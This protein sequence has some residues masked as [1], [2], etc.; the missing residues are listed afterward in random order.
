MKQE[1]I[2]QTKTYDFAVRTI[3]LYKHLSVTKKEYVL[4]KQL[5]RSGTS[6]GANVEEA[7]GA[8]TEKDFYTKL[9]IA[10]KEARETHYWIRLLADTDFLTIREKNSLLQDLDEILKIIGSI[11]ITIQNKERVTQNK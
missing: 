8:Q 4:S 6:I 10:Y 1:N 5:L 2:I 9:S 11:R 7:L 3:R